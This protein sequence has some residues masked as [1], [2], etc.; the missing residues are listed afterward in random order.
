MMKKIFKL[1]LLLFV[2]LVFPAN[3]VAL[4]VIYLFEGSVVQNDTGQPT[5]DI[6]LG[7]AL[8]YTFEIDYEQ[9]GYYVMNNGT[10]GQWPDSVYDGIQFSG[11]IVS[12]RLLSGDG[13]YNNPSSSGYADNKVLEYHEGVDFTNPDTNDW[14][15]TGSEDSWNMLIALTDIHD[16]A[17]DWAE[18]DPFRIYERQYFS[19]GSHVVMAGDLELTQI[20]PVPEPATMLL[21]GSGLLGLAGLRR[22]FLKR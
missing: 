10:V 19:D 2:F 1:C 15:A 20:N 22:K 11:T 13:Y 9:H 8:A 14:L 12:G 4:P 6:P 5:A 7:T 21:L 16:C 3:G 18:G 17:T